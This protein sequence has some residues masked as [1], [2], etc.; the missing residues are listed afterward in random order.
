MFLPKTST[1][2]AGAPSWT[3]VVESKLNAKAH[4]W[5]PS[6]TLNSKAQPW[7]PSTT[8]I[9]YPKAEPWSPMQIRSPPF[10]KRDDWCFQPSSESHDTCSQTCGQTDNITFSSAKQMELYL[11]DV[12]GIDKRDKPC[13]SKWCRESSCRALDGSGRDNNSETKQINRAISMQSAMH[14]EE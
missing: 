9:L 10:V 12:L 3:P 4:P 5:T 14:W 6:S 1:L 2:D 11:Y 7:F 13:S 8:M